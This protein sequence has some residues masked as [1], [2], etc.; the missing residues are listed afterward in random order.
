M[1][2]LQVFLDQDFDPKAYIN[3]ACANKPADQPL[4]RYA[5]ATDHL[6]SIDLATL[7][8]NSIIFLPIFNLTIPNSLRYRYLAE[9]EM[10]LHLGSEDIGLYLQDQST[11]ATQRIPVAARELARI[12]EDAQGVR[13]SVAT[14]LTKLQE[15]GT[16]TSNTAATLAALEEI[17]GVK[18]KM[19]SACHTLKEA[20]GLSTLFSL[21]DDLFTSGD[22]SRAADALAGI[23]RGLVVVADSVPEFRDGRAR[24]ARLEDRFSAAAEAPLAAAM[25][26]QRGDEAASLAN[27]LSSMG[28]SDQVV[29]AYITAR[30]A[31]LWSLWEGYTAG[32]PFVPWLATFYDQV[33]R[34]VAVECEWCKTSL[35]EFYPQLVINLFSSFFASTDQPYRARLAGALTG[36]QG[37]LL[38]L[39]HLEQAAAAVD[40][41]VNSLRRE[42]IEAEAWV[43]SSSS[44]SFSQENNSPPGGGGGG[45]GGGDN[46]DNEQQNQECIQA[47]WQLL[48][49]IVAPV[50][51]AISQ[52]HDKELQYLTAE[53][54]RLL[55]PARELV[56]KA[57]SSSSSA[58]AAS[59]TSTS[60]SALH[61]VLGDTLDAAFGAATAA[62]ARCV[63]LTSG[64][65]L[66]TL[67]RVL[68]RVVQQYISAIQ[69]IITTAF[70]NS[71]KLGGAG[72]VSSPSK[73]TPGGATASTTSAAPVPEAVL[74]LL[75]VI[76]KMQQRLDDCSNEIVQAVSTTVRDVLESSV[77]AD[78]PENEPIRLAAL[79]LQTQT[80]LRPQLTTFAATTAA[81]ANSPDVATSATTVLLGAADSAMADLTFDVDE[82]AERALCG[83][84]AG[85]F[86]AV[87][88][89]PEWQARPATSVQLP[90]F[91]PYPLQYITAAGE[92]LMMLPQVL[93][94]ALATEE[95][96]ES[97]TIGNSTGEHLGESG[98]DTSEAAELV[99]EWVDRAALASCQLYLNQLKKLKGLS[100]QG[101]GQ[102]AADIEYFSNVLS[103][104][105]LAAPSAL[106][107][108]QAALVAPD[109]AALEGLKALAAGEGGNN[110]AKTAVDVV[111]K[112]RAMDL[113]SGGGGSG[114]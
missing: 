42:L 100:P 114:K 77:P 86:A 19:E 59:K 35:P 88:A 107:A 60:S 113:Q 55:A 84:V 25:T 48:N 23:R 51:G 40:D 46:I 58:V 13:A 87:P 44:S 16:T 9:M 61:V 29:S 10:K 110:E 7:I 4:D 21:V 52:Y 69:S 30:C 104:L 90:S 102:L 33:L 105:G 85:H 5:H 22:L 81:A 39:E 1:A 62:V 79:R 91:T 32:T 94:S 43:A 83:R 50:E 27:M 108:W 68:D 53:M 63:R 49:I 3:A 12:R 111:A 31:P 67:T 95:R 101:A 14:A 89:L 38:P 37:S 65:S 64:T 99:A 34:S 73:A 82:L 54:P 98:E 41:F 70:S 78:I 26:N 36:A 24:L 74:P 92:Y 93:E 76:L 47:C 17:D 66:P 56:A 11:R 20:A 8:V 71:T 109:A 103:T 6:K 106:A 80:G 96:N 28:R 57:S 112:L 45:G 18:R 75:L 2:D 72:G 15:T 97:S